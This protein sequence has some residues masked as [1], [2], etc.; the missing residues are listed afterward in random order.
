MLIRG[1]QY[2]TR[3]ETQA[4]QEKTTKHEQL[5]SKTNKAKRNQAKHCKQAKQKKSN[6]GNRT[7]T[8]QKKSEVF[9]TISVL[10]EI[11]A[12]VH[13]FGISQFQN[14][15]KYEAKKQNTKDE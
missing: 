13:S 11:F 12:G 3:K 9:T 14:S 5:K 7:K 6:Q 15:K 1:S 8:E 2:P 4:E 10:S